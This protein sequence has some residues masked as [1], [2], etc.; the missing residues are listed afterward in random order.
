MSLPPELADRLEHL[1][2]LRV[3][4]RQLHGALASQQPRRSA[5]TTTAEDRLVACGASELRSELAGLS[6][7]LDARRATLQALQSNQ[8]SVDQLANAVVDAARSVSASIERRNEETLALSRASRE[9]GE[10]LLRM[11]AHHGLRQP[12]VPP[13][14]PPTAAERAEQLEAARE[15]MRRRGV[16]TLDATL[17]SA[18]STGGRTPMFARLQRLS[19]AGAFLSSQDPTPPVPPLPAALPEAMLHSLRPRRLDAPV[20]ED[21]CSICLSTMCRGDEVLRLA[22]EH[23]F[24][25][26]CLLP[27]LERSA[28]C[29]LCK[30]A[31]TLP[32]A[33]ARLLASVAAASP[34]GAAEEQPAA[35]AERRTAAPGGPLAPPQA[36]PT[37]RALTPASTAGRFGTTRWP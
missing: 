22:C 23:T 17:Y 33:R 13:T 12:T 8:E 5:T 25:A 37:L 36:R 34:R 29:P 27:W 9:Q 31:V 32:L 1:A 7:S 28:C 6:R 2:S 18:G 16:A 4:L 10:R 20:K 14:L 21:P 35:S 26:R 15:R 11:R 24:H 30:G 3:Q 19:E